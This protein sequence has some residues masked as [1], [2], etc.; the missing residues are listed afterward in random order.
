MHQPVFRYK[1][2]SFSQLINDIKWVIESPS[3]FEIAPEN[4]PWE[5]FVI[6]ELFEEMMKNTINSPEVVLDYFNSEE[7][8]ILGKYFEK[9]LGFI[10]DYSKKLEIVAKGLQIFNDSR[11]IGEIDFLLNDKQNKKII[12]L[13]VAV[14]YY[15][16][17]DSDAAWSKWIGPNGADNLERKIDKFAVQLT[18][19]GFVNSEILTKDTLVSPKILLKGYLFRHLNNSRLPAFCSPTVLNGTW[20]YHNEAEQIINPK[21]NYA[22]IPKNRW[23]SFYIDKKIK[24]VSG[25]KIGKVLDEAVF[26]IGKG[27]LLA[28]MDHSGRRI[29]EKYMVVPNNWPDL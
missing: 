14:K 17:T 20:I 28:E 29:V 4:Y 18:M 2:I 10:F 6:P 3:I 26:K 13:E 1:D 12:Q 25:K 16:G 23:L 22:I 27:I 24:I 21:N 5:T 19:A 11:T 7:Q 15:L 8:F 9:L